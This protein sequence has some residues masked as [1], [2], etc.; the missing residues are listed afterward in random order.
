[1]SQTITVKAFL[2]F[3]KERHIK[4]MFEKGSIFLNTV[5]YF[6]NIEDKELRGDKYEGTTKVINSL[7][8][9]F[10]IPE[11]EGEF[12]YQKIHLRQV[13]ERVNGNIYS[14]YT[15]SSK[16]FPNP[17]DF[18]LY[19]RKTRFGTS[20]L[21][22]KNN[23]EFLNRIKS[24]LRKNKYSF[25]SGFIEYYDKDKVSK[26]LTL[27]DKPLEFEYQKEFRFYV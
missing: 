5:E 7:P 16:G 9:T 2:K 6:R 22:V 20:C 19:K 18:K 4:D 1:M 8:G 14:L 12:K 23:E 25:E 17:F 21:L 11:L 27:F 26:D 13:Y 3:G 15:I 24:E 10:T